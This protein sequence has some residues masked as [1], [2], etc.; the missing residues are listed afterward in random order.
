MARTIFQEIVPSGDGHIEVVTTYSDIHGSVL[1]SISG[2][3]LR[4]WLRDV[5]SASFFTTVTLPDLQVQSRSFLEDIGC[6]GFAQIEYAEDVRT[7]EMFFLELNAR[8]VYSNQ[9]FAD[10]GIDLSAIGYLDLNGESPPLES[11]QRDGVYSIDIHRDIP[12]LRGQMAAS[13]DHARGMAPKRSPRFV[14]RELRQGRLQA[15]IT[16]TSRSKAPTSASAKAR[17][18]SPR[19]CMNQVALEPTRLSPSGLSSPPDGDS[20]HYVDHAKT[21]QAH[22]GRCTGG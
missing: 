2:K 21:E 16:S 10:A 14:V 7:G 20:Q 22:T 18:S 1:A 19:C 17:A 6:V 11:R 9:L 3:R 8:T 4:Q 13:R 15:V 5:E 12:I